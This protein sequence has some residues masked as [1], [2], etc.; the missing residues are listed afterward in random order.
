MG[1]GS[2]KKQ[3]AKDKKL[4][5]IKFS[6]DSLIAKKNKKM[7]KFSSKASKSKTF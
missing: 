4:D 3:K 5:N 1:I 2:S 6:F 7:A